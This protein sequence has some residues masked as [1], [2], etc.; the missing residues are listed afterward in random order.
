MGLFDGADTV[1]SPTHHPPATFIVVPKWTPFSGMNFFIKKHVG[2][3][4]L[5]G[6][7][8]SAHFLLSKTIF[9]LHINISYH[10]HK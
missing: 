2:V 8:V 6:S 3:V 5:L 4:G 9:V 10:C 1:S 7:S